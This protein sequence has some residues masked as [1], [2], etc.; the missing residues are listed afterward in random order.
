MERKFLYVL[1]LVGL[2]IGYFVFL[3]R[4]KDDLEQ[5]ETTDNSYLT[6]TAGWLK[7]IDESGDYSILY[8]A[9]WELED[10]SFRNEMIRA[11]ISQDYHT[12]VQIRK[13]N[14][15]NSDL[16]D[17]AE[18]YI[19]NFMDEMQD[20]WR[21]EI[22]EVNRTF[23]YMGENYGCRSEIVMTKANGEEWLFLE[24]IWLREGYALAFQCGTKLDKRSD[25]VPQLDQIAASLEFL[26]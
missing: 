5:L 24:Y 2:M 14:T 8:P 15:R 18:S 9:N 4:D 21:G 7:F 10:N 25:Q 12:G 23:T 3:N 13:I 26:N 11:D 1:V 19:S 17:F 6:D 16:K 20:Y 22:R